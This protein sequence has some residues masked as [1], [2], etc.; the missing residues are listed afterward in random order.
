LVIGKIYFQREE[1]MNNFLTFLFILVISLLNINI[2]IAQSGW[3]IIESD[4]TL[5]LN[6]VNFLDVET[7]YVVGNSG[8]V[9]KTTNAGL[10]WENTPTN[11]SIKLND[12]YF[13]NDEIGLAVGENGTVIKTFN[14]GLNWTTIPTGVADELLSVT[15]IDSFGICG[16]R[17][18]TILY[19]SD[20]GNSWSIAQSNYIGGGFWGVVM[21]SQELGYIGGENSIFQPLVGGTTD[22]GQTWDFTAFYLNN[23]EGRLTGIDFTDLFRGYASARVWDGRGAISKTTDGGEYWSTLLFTSPINSIDFPISNASLVGYAAGDSGN[24]YKSYDAGDNWNQQE[25]ATQ[26]KLNK[27]H[28]IDLDDGYIV[29]DSGIILKTTT[30][31]EPV[32]NT[33]HL[34]FN[35]KS[36][37]EFK[38]FQNYPN[39]FNPTTQIQ[40]N[41]PDAGIVLLKV[42]DVLGNEVVK[43]VNEEKQPGSYDAEFNAVNLA[44]GL[45][46]YRIQAEKFTAIKKLI[47]LK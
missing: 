1:F 3:H 34:E 47:L 19:S 18:Q 42:Y 30:G 20:S 28:F 8:L 15:F 43:L 9:L 33:D 38:L 11:Q 4:T 7:G 27:V 14:G 32:T 25:S 39:P 5:N 10:N 2:S 24:I 29:G 26:L 13:F 23:N 12:L 44:S 35:S 37:S 22:G 41:I 40:Y 31:G 46:I 36:V 17:S 21:L 16:A 6:S 45:Y